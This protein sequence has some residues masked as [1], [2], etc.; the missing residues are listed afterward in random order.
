MFQLDIAVN[1]V[2]ASNVYIFLHNKKDVLLPSFTRLFGSTFRKLQINQEAKYGFRQ[3]LEI[4]KTDLK[5]IDQPN[6]R[7]NSSRD[8]ISAKEC[9][10]T[11]IEKHLGCILPWKQHSFTKLPAC[12]QALQYEKLFGLYLENAAYMDEN[13]IYETMGCLS[14]CEKSKYGIKA[15]AMTT[16]KKYPLNEFKIKLYFT[17]GRYNEKK[18][19]LIYDSNSLIADIGGYLGL[20]LG[21]S[22][23]SMYNDVVGKLISWSKD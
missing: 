12:N 15:R 7:C 13:E 6:S 2:D 22:L 18:Q 8:G 10:D 11:H 23:L 20:L 4:I 17:S 14:S 16:N 3:Y 9:I 21:S 5:N 19:Y 1:V